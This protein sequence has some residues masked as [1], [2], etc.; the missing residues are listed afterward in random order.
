MAHCWCGIILAQN[1]YAAIGTLVLVV[2]GIAIAILVLTHLIGPKRSGAR[3]DDT[4][5]SGMEP[6]GDTRRRFSVR[7]YLIAVLFLIFDVEIVFLYPWAVLAPRLHAPAGSPHHA[8][9]QGLLRDG[10]TPGFMLL[11]IGL[12]FALLLVGFIYEWRR[13]VFKWN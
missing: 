8:W 5:E 3:K 11:A 1:A 10:Y 2:V 4:Y 6:I 13:G 12:F 7:F 9:A